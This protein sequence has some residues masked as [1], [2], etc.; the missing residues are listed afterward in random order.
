LSSGNPIRRRYEVTVK[1]TLFVT[2]VVYAFLLIACRSSSGKADTNSTYNFVPSQPDRVR[3]YPP[4]SVSGKTAFEYFKDEKI[5]SGWNLGN[6]LDS[7]SGGAGSET[8]W[9]NPAINQEI[10]NGVKAAG[11]DIIR[12]PIT[13]I[14]HFGMPPDYRISSARLQRA[15][16][17][18]EMAHNAKLKVIINIH[19]DGS[20]PQEGKEN[21]WLS[22]AKSSKNSGE[23]E[24][25][26][27]Q[28]AR[29]WDQLA[30]YFQNYGDWLMFESMNEIHDGGWGWS[31]D[32]KT[33]PKSQT[34]I[35][36]KWNQIFTDRVRAAGGNNANRY[37]IIP[38]YCTIPEQTLSNYFVLP[39]DVTPNKQIV[40]FHY[41]DP[42][43][44]SIQGTR[45]AWGTDNDKQKVDKDF[46]PFQKR[47][48]ENNIPVIIGET[49]A[50]LQLR[51]N[52]RAVE[53][54]ARQSRYDY[55]SYVFVTAKKYGL[56]PFYWDN[57]VTSGNGEKFGLFDRKTG[58]PNSADSAAFINIMINSVK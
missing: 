5:F 49:G 44:F 41:Y 12:I 4:E 57:G 7:Y 48:L 10:M 32:F 56:V 50:V 39:N 20:T 55:I 46:S 28:F 31:Y 2:F 26:T 37:L 24:K 11:F 16:E 27:H 52:D 8:I 1:K 15:A 18:V 36:N 34:D 47:F 25:I 38:A 19:H 58:Q 54:Q 9:G 29:V 42:H 35:I 45:P 17:V 53:A 40:T 43:E 13:W 3:E 23:Y 14:G 6:T 22:I 51:P 33:F 21:G 30:A